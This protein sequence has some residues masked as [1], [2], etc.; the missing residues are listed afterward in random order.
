MPPEMGESVDEPAD[1]R[2][3]IGGRVAGE[4]IS[5]TAAGTAET[6]RGKTGPR[7]EVPGPK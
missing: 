5:G 2:Y 7:A 3:T 4:A 1:G 6:F